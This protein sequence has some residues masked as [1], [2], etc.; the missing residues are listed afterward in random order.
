MRQFSRLI[1]ALL[2]LAFVLPLSA[3]DPI[4]TA[5]KAYHAKTYPAVDYHNDEKVGIA[6]DPYDMPE[7]TN[8]VLVVDYRK[9]ELMPIYVIFSNDGDKTINLTKM[10]VTLIT[11]KR[12]KIEPATP[13]DIYRKIAEM[14][15]PDGQQVQLPIPI[16]I[17]KNKPSVSAAAQAEV[18]NSGMLA[19]AIEPK[20]TRAGFMVFDVTGIENPLAGAR[21][22]ITNLYDEDGKQLFFFEIPMEKYLGYQPTKMQ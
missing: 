12:T 1:L 6:A 16:K 8:G 2:L 21:L 5:P 9:A 3:K 20:T 17:K 7:K 18:E 19:K 10:K 22:E 11:K 15:R 4:Y 14:H 13:D